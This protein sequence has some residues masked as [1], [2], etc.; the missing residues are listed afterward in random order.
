MM[1][2]SRRG[3]RVL[4]L[5]RHRLRFLL[6]ELLTGEVRRCCTQCRRADNAK[7]FVIVA[8]P[9]TRQGLDFRTAGWRAA[10]CR[11]RSV[12]AAAGSVRAILVAVADEITTVVR[13]ASVLAAA[14]SVRAILVAKADE[15]TTMS[16]TGAILAAALV[17][18]ALRVAVAEASLEAA[19]NH[20]KP[21]EAGA[22][23]RTA[24]VGVAAGEDVIDAAL[25]L[26]ADARAANGPLRAIPVAA[27]FGADMVQAY[28]AAHQPRAAIELITAAGDEGPVDDQ[29]A[30]LAESGTAELVFDTVALDADLT[31]PAVRVAA[32]FR[33]DQH[34]F[35]TTGPLPDGTQDLFRLA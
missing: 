33:T 7:P 18:R 17:L 35:D 4:L 11:T 24:F 8:N 13:A 32:A 22:S 34:S 27:A 16:G 29:A 15:I 9:G 21:L 12:L 25:D 1:T 30:F 20:A 14:A 3:R 28:L 19:G 23:L 2:L 6:A 10:G 5:G 31:V 26:A